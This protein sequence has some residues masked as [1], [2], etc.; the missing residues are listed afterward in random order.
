WFL[1]PRR[2]EGI[3]HLLRAARGF[4]QYSLLDGL[5]QQCTDW[6]EFGCKLC[7]YT[8]PF[9]KQF[10]RVVGEPHLTVSIFPRQ[11]FHWKVD[12]RRW[13]RHH[14]CGP[15]FRIAENQ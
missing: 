14:Q 5:L 15:A 4:W 6:V 8:M 10:G 3:C 2:V 7:W 9:L 13:S 11:G 12:C 1:S